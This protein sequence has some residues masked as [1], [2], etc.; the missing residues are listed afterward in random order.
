M[1]IQYA[2]TSEIDK[3]IE[4]SEKKVG[5]EEETTEE[6][7]VEETA[8][9]TK[10]KSE[11]SLEELKGKESQVTPEI[12]PE[13]EKVV[14]NYDYKKGYQNL[15]SLMD[16]QAQE[17]GELRKLRQEIDAK[18]NA[19]AQQEEV[20][21]P[22]KLQELIIENP[23]KFVEIVT[24]QAMTAA[25]QSIQQEQTETERKKIYDDSFK[26]LTEFFG[27]EPYSNYDQ[28]Q[29]QEFMDF[30]NDH[31]PVNKAI[32]V[33]DLEK[34]HKW[35]HLDEAIEQAK[36]SGK[37][38]VLETISDTSPKVKTLSTQQ[39]AKAKPDVDVSKLKSRE[40]AERFA[41]TLS[42]DE[43]DKAILAMEN[44]TQ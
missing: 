39:Q 32:T 15:K 19:N 22:E 23:T 12:K 13:P 21:T 27:K 2:D 28:A 34:Y 9:E 7:K 24:K 18:K 16:R 8:V 14:D 36:I 44:L 6:T 20:I 37:Q 25:K 33:S 26:S 35:M 42:P 30:V 43:L 4:E 5:T 29:V 38:K 40:D 31:R 11:V 1:A 41:E 3:Q 10:E 17:L